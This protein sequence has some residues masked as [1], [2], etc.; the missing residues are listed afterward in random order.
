MDNW[1]N[2][3]RH[4]RNDIRAK[5]PV[6]LHGSESGHSACF[7]LLSEYTKNLNVTPVLHNLAAAVFHLSLVS[8]VCW[9]IFI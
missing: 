5:V 1:P 8:K 7:R 3:I 4:A 2:L 9:R 6:E